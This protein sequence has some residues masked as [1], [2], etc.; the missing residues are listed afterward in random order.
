M[1]LQSER[2]GGK[3]SLY[4]VLAGL[5]L[6]VVAA[7]AQTVTFNYSFLGGTNNA[8]H[9]VGTPATDG[10]TL[11]GV[12]L[13]GGSNN[14]GVIFS[15][16]TNGANEQIVHSFSG[17][18]SDGC[19]P[20]GS[21][22]LAGD[23]PYGTAGFPDSGRIFSVTTNGTVFQVLRDFAGGDNDGSGPF[24]S[25]ALIIAGETLY[26]VTEDGGSNNAGVVYGIGTNGQNFQILY[27]F[28][29]STDGEHPDAPLTLVGGQLFGVTPPSSTDDGTIFSVSTNGVG[30]QTLHTFTDGADGAFPGPLTL[31]DG[32]LFGVTSA[33]GSAGNGTLYAINTDGNGFH[34]LRPFGITGDD[35]VHTLTALALVGGTLY[36]SSSQGGSKSEGA[37]FSISTN[38]A[39]Y[40]LVYSFGTAT[41]DG[42]S[43]GTYAG[44]TLIGT[45]LF[46][47]TYQGGTDSHGTV[48]ELQLGPDGSLPVISNIVT[49]AFTNV[50]Q[51]CKTKTKIDK[52][53]MTTNVTTTCK[54]SV[55]FVVTNTGITNSPAFEVDL[56]ASQGDIFDILVGPPPLFRKVKALKKGQSA[57]IK[58]GGTF[59]SDQSG[60]FIFATD[61]NINVI[62]SIEVP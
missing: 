27:S 37:I 44:L 5:F 7:P 45:N 42:L 35:A 25:T 48:Y 46:G 59:D 55:E 51:T 61:S 19:C 1:K 28:K 18:G 4:S 49:Y 8:G 9:I 36:G 52:K 11:Y 40:G 24:Q 6:A 56:F 15:V 47:F 60:T 23:T 41:E 31:G 3:F 21:V 33:G 50:V 2:T 62:A 17:S 57:I 34:V 12:G 10:A 58:V 43:P 13:M 54:L 22:V 39:D 38:G 16:G 53:T 32:M 20:D 30:F 29:N 26:G 14:M